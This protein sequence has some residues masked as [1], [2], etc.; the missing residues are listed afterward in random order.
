MWRVMMCQVSK[1]S[2]NVFWPQ[3]L[4]NQ[5]VR[6]CFIINSNKILDFVGLLIGIIC[7]QKACGVPKIKPIIAGMK[8]VG[9]WILNSFKNPINWKPKYSLFCKKGTEAVKNS[10]P[11]QIS[12]YAE[13]SE[14]RFMCGG[15]L[16]SNQWIRNMKI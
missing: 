13:D 6:C 5:L 9:G 15:T 11:W 12:L 3:K 4:Q 16:I 8:I 1:T 10:I 14:G 7:K 2:W